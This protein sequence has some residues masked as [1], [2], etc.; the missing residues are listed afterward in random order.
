MQLLSTIKPGGCRVVHLL[1]VLDPDNLGTFPSRIDNFMVSSFQCVTG[2]A[3]S[4]SMLCQL[5]FR[6]DMRG[7]GILGVQLLAGSLYGTAM[8][9]YALVGQYTVGVP[10]AIS[11]VCVDVTKALEELGMAYPKLRQLVSV[12]VPQIVC[13]EKAL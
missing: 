10:S 12:L 2:V 5:C 11:S 1:R 6:L 9:K 13:P 7:F 4:S 8:N 3:L